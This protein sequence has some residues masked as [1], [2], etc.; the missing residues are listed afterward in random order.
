MTN[1]YANV[2]RALD[3]QAPGPRLHVVGPNERMEP[4]PGNG[5]WR[6]TNLDDYI[7]QTRAQLKVRMWVTSAMH[8]GQ[9]PGHILLTGA[10]GLGKTSLAAIIAQMLGSQLHTTTGDA[11]SRPM[12]LAR[13]LTGVREGD[14]VFIDEIHQMKLRGEE[15]LGLAMEDFRITVPGNNQG[16]TIPV[17]IDIPRCTVIGATTR[18]AHLSRPLRDRFPLSVALEFYGVDDLG[19][20]LR[21]R[22]TRVGLDITE[23]AIVTLA[24]VGRE[25]PRKALAILD[26]VTAYADTIGAS[27]VDL[28][29]AH[30]ALEVIGVDTLGLDERDRDYCGAI[31]SRG[32][33]RIGLAPLVSITGLNA[34]E[35]TE[36]IEPFPTRI[37]VI[38]MAPRGRRL[39]PKG[40]RHLYPDVP[41]PP[42]LA[43]P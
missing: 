14:C 22:A 2:A 37:G 32:G 29:T 28:E 1:G 43:L 23:D 4:V 8:R 9:Q 34:R 40:Y 10:A 3:M 13:F 21:R 18:P 24:S 38:D 20:I 11:V 33:A 36:D 6:P 39:S 30:G 5:V 25:T 27:T 15:M 42:L 17:S 19:E 16:T 41:L 7:G 35:I 26:L 31:A 12:Q